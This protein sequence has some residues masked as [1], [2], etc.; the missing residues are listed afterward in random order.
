[1]SLTQNETQAA[2]TTNSVNIT[3]SYEDASTRTVKFTGVNASAL[4]NVGAR[5]RAINNNMPANF[6]NT[7]VS[8]TGAKVMQIGKA[9]IVSET[10]EVIYNG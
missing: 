6:K 3:L 1:M 5:V 9:Q 7:F 2:E 4:G 10:K 8:S